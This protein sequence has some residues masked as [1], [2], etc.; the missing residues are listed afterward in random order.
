MPQFSI[1]MASRLADY[2]G[3]A[4][5]R[6]AKLVRAVNSVINQTFTDW[7][8][9]IIADGCLKTIEVV[10]DNIE[11]ERVKLMKVEFTMIWSGTPRHTGIENA[12]GDWIIYLD[13]DDVFGENHL[14]IVS[15]GIGSYDWIWFDDFR[16]HPRLKD[17]YKNH[18]DIKKMGK[19]GTSNVA[20]KRALDV[21]WDENGKYSH[22]YYFV[23]KL[24]KYRNNAKAQTPEY[25]VCHVPG[26]NSNGYDI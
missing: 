17:W 21:R 11:D 15:E 5:N 22:D 19:H 24:M 16:Y 3:A 23:Q 1:I 18:C 13:I 12:V 4:K 7:E 6:E 26:N 9:L 25:F 2:P 8:L 20:H 14:K 10:T